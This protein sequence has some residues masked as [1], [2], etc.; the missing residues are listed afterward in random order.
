VGEVCLIPLLI[1]LCWN[2]MERVGKRDAGV[3]YDMDGW[4][5]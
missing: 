3:F 5:E 4:Y 2:R 1:F